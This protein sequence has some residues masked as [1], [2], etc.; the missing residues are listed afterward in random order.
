LISVFFQQ[1]SGVFGY[2]GIELDVGTGVAYVSSYAVA[3][4]N[5][6]NKN[7]IIIT[8]RWRCSAAKQKKAK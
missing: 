3:T 4:G 8:S 2:Y 7:V 6:W 1:L 5:Q